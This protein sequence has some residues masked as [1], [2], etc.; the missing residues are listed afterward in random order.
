MID[1]AELPELEGWLSFPV[2]ADRLKVTRQRLHQMLQEGKFET[3][4]RIPGT[5]KRPAGYVIREAEV[6][7]ILE[8][9]AVRTETE[10]PEPETVP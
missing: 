1:L 10:V 4:R 7:K 3:A 5:G 8:E 6:N 9:Q 2:A